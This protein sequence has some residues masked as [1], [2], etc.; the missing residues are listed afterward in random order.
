LIA[1]FLAS[2][3]SITCVVYSVRALRATIEATATDPAVLARAL[4]LGDSLSPADAV[5]FGR[6]R[7]VRLLAWARSE[8]RADLETEL[9][10]AVTLHRGEAQIAL[11]NS[12]LGEIDHRVQRHG[13]VPRVCARVS[14]T[15]G[16]LCGAMALRH[17]LVMG[18]LDG[19]PLDLIL[20]GPIADMLS[21]VFM[22]IAG[23]VWCSAAAREVKKVA[24]ERLKGH[25]ALIDRLEALSLPVEEPGQ[26]GE[27]GQTGQ[28]GQG[29]AKAEV[30]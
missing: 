17:G 2:L 5:A 9:L 1:F 28:T 16:L 11:V 23:A 6:R 22:G 30:I 12:A 21:A 13:R 26:T 14:S 8:P 25:D 18:S 19:P 10:E 24:G 3:V 15:V 4:R 29:P 7:L 20:H 27:A